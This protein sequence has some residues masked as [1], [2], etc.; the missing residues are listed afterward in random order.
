MA[1]TRTLRLG[2][3]GSTLARA[4]S[5]HVAQALAAVAERAGADLQVSRSLVRTQGDVDPTALA[6][7][8]GAGVFTAALRTALLQGRCDLAV[9]SLKDLPVVPA[10]GLTLVAVPTRQDPRD[11]LCATGGAAEGLTVADLPPGARVGTGSPRRAAQLLAARPDLR[12]VEIRGN[13][14]TRLARVTGASARPDGPMGAREADLDAVVLAL[15]GLRRL[16]LEDH[17]SQVLPAVDGPWAAP[18]QDPEAGPAVP[19][20]P[21]GPVMVPAPGQ[22]ALAVEVRTELVETD[23]DV[24]ALLAAL[25]DAATRT[26][27]TAERAV[28]HR[29]QA[30][31]AAPVGALAT[32]EGRS[33]RLEAVIAAVDGSALVRRSGHAPLDLAAGDQLPGAAQV[34]GEAVADELVAAGASELADLGAGWPGRSRR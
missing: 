13:V 11:A 15:A 17:V 16:D 20:G 8:G 24:A 1:V 4:Q 25:D 10:P 32:V 6:R 34:L 29:L 26:A 33:L 5:G 30:G 31:C 9:H 28:L 22:G 2:T 7:L 3:R 21:G 18:A 12:I 27:V 23:P 14:P 19:R